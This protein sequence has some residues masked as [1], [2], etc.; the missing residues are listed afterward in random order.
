MEKVKGRIITGLGILL[1][2]ILTIVSIWLINYRV[3]Y[4]DNLSSLN[5]SQNNN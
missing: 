2:Y 4:L 3:D 5:I 1:V